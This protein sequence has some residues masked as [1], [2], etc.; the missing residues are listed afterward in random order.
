[1]HFKE[2][3]W[4]IWLDSTAIYGPNEE[5]KKESTTKLWI[6]KWFLWSFQMQ[7]DLNEIK[8]LKGFTGFFYET[9]II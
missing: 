9:F 6:R 5:Q 3:E 8:E 7:Y 2:H 1:M 4:G